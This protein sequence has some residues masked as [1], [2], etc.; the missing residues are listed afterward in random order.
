MTARRE[1]RL[2]A[3]ATWWRKRL[4]LRLARSHFWRSDAGH[5]V[6]SW[7]A[8]LTAGGLG[9]AGGA[10]CVAGEPA[11]PGMRAVALPMATFGVLLSAGVMWLY[12]ATRR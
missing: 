5:G 3:K 4:V 2:R 9:I 1:G 10:L 8:I 6:P 7:W 12:R 11:E